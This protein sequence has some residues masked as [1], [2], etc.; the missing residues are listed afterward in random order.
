MCFDNLPRIRARILGYWLNVTHEYD[1]EYDVNEGNDLIENK[2]NN[3][4][5]RTNT[6]ILWQPTR[7]CYEAMKT[8][9]MKERRK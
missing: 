8:I 6:L 4:C 1:V 2:V 7:R 3:E 5:M 9:E